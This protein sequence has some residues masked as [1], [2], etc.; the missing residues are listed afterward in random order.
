[1][2]TRCLSSARSS[3]I[4]LTLLACVLILSGPGS[5]YAQVKYTYS[6]NPFNNLVGVECPPICRATG[7]FT[8]ATPLPPN[9]QTFVEE[10]YNFVDFSFTNGSSVFT[11]LNCRFWSI[12][13]ETDANGEIRMWDLVFRE[14]NFHS[15]V[16]NNFPLDPDLGR[17]ATDTTVEDGGFAE[18]IH[19]G[20]TW[21]SSATPSL[22]IVTSSPL[23]PALAGHAYN[24]TIHATGGRPPYTWTQ[25]PATGPFLLGHFGFLPVPI[26]FHQVGDDAVLSSTAAASDYSTGAYNFIVTVKD[27]ANAISSATFTVA[28]SCGDARDLIIPE[29]QQYGIIDK[30]RDWIGF[31]PTCFQFTSTVAD[32]YFTFDQLNASNAVAPAFALISKP[33]ITGLDQWMARLGF[34]PALNSAYRTPFDQARVYHFSADMPVGGRHMF[35]DA[36]DLDVPTKSRLQWEEMVIAALAAG[37]TAVELP[38]P[39][40]QCYQPTAFPAAPYR[41]A[42]ADWRTKTLLGG[43]VSSPPSPSVR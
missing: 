14:D 33:F 23:A 43:Y 36:A 22:Q 18:T 39:R 17:E 30:A 13:V 40:F 25:A 27:A 15:L 37:A 31:Q 7:S 16:I 3:S 20:G 9:S 34:R 5:A 2:K 1:M 24:T 21:T 19:N 12:Y 26:T 42:H 35:G 28:A 6:G 32:V 11:E 29:Y 38:D 4:L 8:I 41:C 10:T